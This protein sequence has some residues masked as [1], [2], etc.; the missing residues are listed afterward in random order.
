MN[1]KCGI[2]MWPAQGFWFCE[3]GNGYDPVEKIWVFGE[4]E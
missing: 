3:C 4:E 2:Q 1:C